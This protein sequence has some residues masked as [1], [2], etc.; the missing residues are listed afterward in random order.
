[1]SKRNV[2]LNSADISPSLLQA[3]KRQNITSYSPQGAS[4][5]TGQDLLNESLQF[6]LAAIMQNKENG[7]G[8][9]GQSGHLSTPIFDGSETSSTPKHPHMPQFVTSDPPQMQS[10]G[11]PLPNPRQI[12]QA[13]CLI[14]IF[15]VSPSP[16]KA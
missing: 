8:K 2:S 10:L 11:A 5:L 16:S 4:H 9:V 14:T 13:V 1:M 7:Q 3:Y 15:C 6:K 12:H